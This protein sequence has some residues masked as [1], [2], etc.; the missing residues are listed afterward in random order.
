MC[1]IKK[2]L[3]I[4]TPK[5]KHICAHTH[6]HTHTIFEAVH[7]FAS[8]QRDIHIW[9][10][11]LFFLFLHI[12][13]RTLSNTT[14]QLLHIILLRTADWVGLA[15]GFHLTYLYVYKYKNT[16]GIQIHTWEFLWASYIFFKCSCHFLVERKC[17]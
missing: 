4:K 2:K 14:Q 15:V 5:N 16:I 17:F 10:S 6:K 12:E 8:F 11:W 13:D 3:F 9:N 7:C 1:F